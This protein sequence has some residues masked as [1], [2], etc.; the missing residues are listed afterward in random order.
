MHKQLS[1]GSLVL[2]C[3]FALQ[4]SSAKAT[5]ITFT[6]NGDGPVIVNINL[7]GC[8]GCIQ[9]IAQGAVEAGVA[10]YTVPG[11]FAG[12]PAGLTTGQAFVVEAAGD[13][14]LAGAISDSVIVQIQNTPNVIASVLA[15][16]TSN[17]DD[18]TT[19]PP[20]GVPT[21]PDISHTLD[22]TNS[23]VTQ[24][25]TGFSPLTLPGNLTIQV[26]EVPEPGTAALLAS[27]LLTC[28]TA[29]TRRHKQAL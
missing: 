21:I 1:V 28:L 17:S 7:A 13:D 2:T 29:V 27:G 3:L 12:F 9:F 15:N 16:F 22:L 23:F 6:E 25:A 8:A 18:V 10:G 14:S 24:T 26:G 5:T 20:P 19:F 11:G 4:P